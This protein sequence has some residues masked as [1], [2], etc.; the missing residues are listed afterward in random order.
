[1]L[2][3]GKSHLEIH[4]SRAYYTQERKC[5]VMEYVHIQPHNGTLIFLSIS[6][7]QDHPVLATTMPGDPCYLRVLSYWHL[8]SGG[9]YM[10]SLST[11]WKMPI[12][13]I[14]EQEG[15]SSFHEIRDSM[16]SVI[17]FL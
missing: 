2:R 11:P 14:V 17:S 16:Y 15:K 5:W 4:S 7:A 8:S 10:F 9:N 13:Y 3:V 12:N 6:S 1:M